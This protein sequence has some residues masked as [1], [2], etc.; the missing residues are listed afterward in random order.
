MAS[1]GKDTESCQWFVTHYQTSHLDG[2]YTNFARTTKGFEVVNN[3]R[4]GDTIFTI[5]PK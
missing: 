5:I 4:V 2:F 1:A 3:L